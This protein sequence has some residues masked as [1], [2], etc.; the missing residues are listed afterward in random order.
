[1]SER[2]IERD[3]RGR[4]IVYV[5]DEKYVPNTF[6]WNKH[7]NNLV[8][9]G[10]M[11]RAM[12][13]ARDMM[14]LGI[15][16]DVRTFTTLI[17]GWCKVG[18]MSLAMHVTKVMLRMGLYPNEFTYARLIEGY[19]Q[20]H[21]MMTAKRLVESMIKVNLIPDIITLNQII[22]RKACSSSSIPSRALQ[23]THQPTRTRR[24]RVAVVGQRRVAPTQRSQCSRTLSL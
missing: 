8:E 5:I 11:E 24:K 4:E 13:A 21:E 14:N 23:R 16:P 3:E 9:K 1:M 2:M 20:Q 12:S 6:K 10:K 22:K 17:K 7:I 19:C 18:K 15:E